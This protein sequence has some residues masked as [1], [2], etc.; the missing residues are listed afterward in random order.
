M[1][2]SLEAIIQYLLADTDLGNLVGT[3]VA[4]KHRYGESWTV[5]DAGIMVR[6]DGGSPEIFVPVQQPRLEIRIYGDGTTAVTSV[7]FQLVTI[8]RNTDREVVTL[9]GDDALMYWF[10]PISGLSMLFDEEV[11]MDMGMVF[12]EACVGEIGL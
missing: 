3:R 4:A 11:G 10:L 9:T 12:F 6:L 1:I 8:S 5:G 7:F 2:D